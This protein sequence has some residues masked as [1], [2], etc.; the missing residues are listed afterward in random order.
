MCTCDID[1]TK[2]QLQNV[3]FRLEQLMELLK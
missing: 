3:T 1:K 2:H